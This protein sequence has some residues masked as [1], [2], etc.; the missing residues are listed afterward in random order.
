MNELVS[1]NI[2]TWNS[3]NY[4]EKCLAA[5]F[6]Q[7]YK[8]IEINIL[9]NGSID[10][11]KEL[12]ERILLKKSFKINL[13]YEEKNIG[14]AAGH[15]K[16]IKVSRGEFII[17]LNHDVILADDFIEKAVSGFKN[18][19]K[20]SSLQAKIYQY[21]NGQKTELIDTVGFGVFKS[22][23]IIDEGQ[24]QKDTGQFR[25]KREIFGANGAAP[26]YRRTALNDIR[27]IN[28]LGLR[29][30]YFDEDFFAYVE[31]ID[32]AW[33]LQWRGWRCVYLP[34]LIAWHDR[35]TSKRH[36]KSYLDFIR[37]RRTQG[38][39]A[40]KIA[41][42]NQWFLWVKNQPVINFLKFFPWFFWRQIRLFVY[43]IFFE[44]KTLLAIPE[45]IKLIPLML[46]KR[47]IIMTTK[48]ISDKK[49]A[50]WFK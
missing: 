9:D 11:T 13:F 3:A 48:K 20:I 46:R 40:R 41:W 6:S 24:G 44:Q 26:V 2:L 50:R 31:D 47:K 34:E 28:V 38:A 43:L 4:L 5:V 12:L 15:N 25:K 37:H 21:N 39:W 30:E 18:D 42:R 35:T 29:E 10:H 36:K 8:N 27:L 33:R 14:Y 45:V 49:M 1:V 32:L 16:L 19:K 17:I 22:G 7:T 23:R